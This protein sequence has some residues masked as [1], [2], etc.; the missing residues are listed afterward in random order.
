MSQYDSA[1]SS[2][3]Q[4]TLCVSPGFS[5]SL[6]NALSARGGCGTSALDDGNP[7]Y[8]CAIAQPGR[9]PVLATL[10]ETSAPFA[11]G[12]TWRS[13]ISNLVYDRPKPNGYAGVRLFA[14]N[15]R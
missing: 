14:S 6:R 4:L 5:E 1:R 15:Q 9:E 2:S 12:A 3:V 11:L 10:K 8:T 7:R 13:R